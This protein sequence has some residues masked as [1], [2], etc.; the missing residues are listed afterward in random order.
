MILMFVSSLVGCGD[1]LI[2]NNKT[3][4]GSEEII[5]VSNHVKLISPTISNSMEAGTY[6][7]SIYNLSQNTR[8]LIKLVGLKDAQADAVINDSREVHVVLREAEQGNDL[9]Y[10]KD[11]LK[12]CPLTT[13]WAVNATW[14]YSF[15]HKFS[16]K[17]GLALGDFDLDGCITPEEP[18]D[19]HLKNNGNIYFK[20]NDWFF[21][22][23]NAV[24]NNFGF[25]VISKVN[26]KS[27]V[28]SMQIIH[29]DSGG[30][31]NNLIILP[32]I[33]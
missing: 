27:L 33:S 3:Y 18:A 20:I 5:S 22:Y 2:K 13:N 7:Q 6:Q 21:S 32:F 17:N 15:R 23:R 14:N 19:D 12:I 8:I 11:N 16:S 29:L 24:E 28:I 26:I 4:I 25:V 10:Y 1:G 30:T 31:L 9:T